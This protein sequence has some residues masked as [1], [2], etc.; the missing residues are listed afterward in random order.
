MYKVNKYI[1]NKQIIGRF[2]V[3]NYYFLLLSRLYCSG[4]LW[5]FIKCTLCLAADWHDENTYIFILAFQ[6]FIRFSIL[7]RRMLH[8]L[9]LYHNQILVKMH[10]NHHHILLHFYIALLLE[11]LLNLYEAFETIS[12]LINPNHQIN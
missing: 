2:F 6:Q 4:S 11:V 7:Y 1:L 3:K 10:W 12:L 8:T 5:T 9:I